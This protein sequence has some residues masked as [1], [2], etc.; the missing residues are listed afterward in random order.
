[1]GKPK[2]LLKW[3]SGSLLD[4]AIATALQVNA[5]DIYVILGAQH[6][7][8]KSTIDHNQSIKILKNN[9]WHKGLGNSIACA[10][11]HLLESKSKVDG[12]LFMLADQP[13]MDSDFLN[14]LIGD[15]RANENLIIATSYGVKK[16][17]VPVVFDK[18]Y[19]EALSNL[20]D[21]FGAKSILQANE[22]Y[23]KTLIPPVKNV[24]LDSQ[25]DYET[26]YKA[27][28]KN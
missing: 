4:H 23:I 1:M 7:T 12:L 6:N 11:K 18:S 13:L 15:F 24:D 28:F 17:G 21:D 8:I 10:A 27:N 16:Q 19:L 9:N 26:L 2:Q 14:S 5:I 22:S 25:H 20:D 3:G